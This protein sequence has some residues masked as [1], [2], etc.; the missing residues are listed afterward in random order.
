MA[1][2]DRLHA[3]LI[4]INDQTGRPTRSAAAM[5]RATAARWGGPA[6]RDEYTHWKW[7]P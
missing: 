7:P 6:D 3:G 4:H 5:R 1:I 2:D